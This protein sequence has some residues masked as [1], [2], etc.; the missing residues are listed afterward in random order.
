ML[1]LGF[2]HSS[3]QSL[4]EPYGLQ[5]ITLSLTALG[6][7]KMPKITNGEIRIP[8]LVTEDYNY[9]LINEIISE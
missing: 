3:T 4:E 1:I 9:N 2:R 6:S 5:T 8:F 7:A